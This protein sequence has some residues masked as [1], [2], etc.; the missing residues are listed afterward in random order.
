M[1]IERPR[2]RDFR[3]GH[4]IRIDVFKA[5]GVDICLETLVLVGRNLA[6]LVVWI[7]FNHL[8]IGILCHVSWSRTIFGE[9][10]DWAARAGSG[11]GGESSSRDASMPCCSLCNLFLEG[12]CRVS[13][14]ASEFGG[15]Y[16][17]LIKFHVG[18]FIK[19]VNFMRIL[20]IVELVVLI[21]LIVFIF[22]DVVEVVFVVN[23]VRGD[24][25]TTTL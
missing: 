15:V 23:I 5:R 11:S 10:C 2:Q 20:F 8:E 21:F 17:S 24:E 6:I 13:S 12:A 7:A 18:I 1:A 3:A 9:R 4:G 16:L 25:F 14:S 19:D 22:R